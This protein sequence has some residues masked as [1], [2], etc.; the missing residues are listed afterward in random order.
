MWSKNINPIRSNF[1]LSRIIRNN[2]EI[3]RFIS[4]QWV[5]S[6]S[7][8]FWTVCIPADRFGCAPFHSWVENEERREAR[9]QCAAIT[10]TQ[11][12]IAIAAGWLWFNELAETHTD[13][14]ATARRAQAQDS[15]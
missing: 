9:V 10:H 2:D 6:K 1:I 7:I 12:I 14:I 8:I 5:T 13:D 4:V 11:Y 3:I 15:S